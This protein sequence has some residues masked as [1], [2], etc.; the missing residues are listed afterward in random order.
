MLLCTIPYFKMSN[1]YVFVPPVLCP[2]SIKD[3]RRVY[4]KICPLEEIHFYNSKGP[5]VVFIYDQGVSL[6]EVVKTSLTAGRTVI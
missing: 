5:L 4:H 6:L 1:S 3:R 2:V